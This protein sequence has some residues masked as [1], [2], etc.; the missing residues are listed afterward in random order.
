MR[1]GATVAMAIE[2]PPT[3]SCADANKIN[4]AEWYPAYQSCVRHFVNVAQHEP[5]TQSFAAF[6]N[7]LLPCQKA[8]D[9]ILQFAEAPESHESD[10]GSTSQPRSGPISLVPYVRRLVVTATDT[11]TVLR[12]LF[13]E[14]W[15]EGVGHIH[16]HERINYLFAAKSSG[17]LRTKEQYDVSPE[18]TVPFLSPLRDPQE[19]EIRVAEA[20]WSEWLAMEDWMVGPRSPWEEREGV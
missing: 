13:G 16:S 8:H 15:L 11:P 9:P 20:R 4:P 5:A 17:W 10:Y 1:P 7:I 19:D 6:I 18:E 2:M 3:T 12:E 14:N